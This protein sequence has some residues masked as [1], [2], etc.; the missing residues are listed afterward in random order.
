LKILLNIAFV[1]G[2]CFIVAGIGMW[3]IPFALIVGGILTVTVCVLM[4]IYLSTR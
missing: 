4:Q 3:S 2:L 1:A